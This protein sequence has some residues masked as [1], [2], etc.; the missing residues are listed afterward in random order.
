MAQ[1]GLAAAAFVLSPQVA[2]AQFDGTP[3]SVNSGSGNSA[4]RGG[5][6][7]ASRLQ[8][9]LAGGSKR[10]GELRTFYAA[11]QYRPLWIEGGEISGAADTLLRLADTARID[12]LNRKALRVDDLL[13]ALRRSNSGTPKDM[14]RAELAL[15]RTLAAYVQGTRIARDSGMSYQNSLLAPVVPSIGSA[16]GTAAQA[17]SLDAYLGEM[18]WMHPLYS[19]LRAALAE[20]ELDP[21]ATQLVQLNLERARALPANPA[22]RYVLI[23]AAGASL[24]MY[25]NGKVVDTMRVVVGK[26]SQPTPMIA[27]ELSSAILNPYWNVPPD[28]VRDRIAYNVNTKGLGYLKTGGYQV[29]SDWSDNAKVVSPAKVDWRAVAAGTKEQRVRQLPGRANFMGKVKFTFPNNLGIYLHDTPDKALLKE[30]TR[31]ASSG[32]VRLEDAARLGR[33]LFGRTLVPSRG[34]VEQTVALDQPVPVYITY[35]TAAPDKGRIVFRE[36][37]YDRDQTQLAVLR[38]ADRT[39]R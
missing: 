20:R 3:G 12:G 21:A 5:D 36:D 39:S 14:A 22:P 6:A 25:E 11:R 2:Y 16:L 13:S 24:S 23:D 1:L 30:D 35:L 38:R 28:L 29:L 18:R 4:Y 17:D 7:L 10:E 26:P 34:A 33:W 8:A 15:S 37:T 31:Q 19:Q 32:C 27:G 9:E